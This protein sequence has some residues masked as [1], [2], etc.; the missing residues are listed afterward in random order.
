MHHVFVGN[1]SLAATTFTLVLAHLEIC[2]LDLLTQIC[3]LLSIAGPVKCGFEVR[4]SAAIVTVGCVVV[5]GA[6]Q[7]LQDVLIVL[8]AA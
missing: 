4:L 3:Q 1:L 2:G 5:V 8:V 6:T 7:L